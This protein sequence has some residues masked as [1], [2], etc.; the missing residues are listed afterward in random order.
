[1]QGVNFGR[2]YPA[3]RGQNCTP[4]N[5]PDISI[6]TYQADF[7]NELPTILKD[8]PAD[9]FAF[10]FVD[11][12]GWRIRLSDLA[13]MLGRRKSEVIFNFMFDFINRAASIKDPVVISGLDEL[14]PHGNWRMSLEEAERAQPSGLNSED[15]KAILVQAFAE[16]LAQLGSYAYVAETTVLRPL[17]D[18]P[19]YCLFYATR[20]PTGME[21]FRDCQ[22]KALTEQSKTR[23]ATKVK[24][25]ASSSGQG[26]F[27]QSLH[28]MGPDELTSFLEAQRGEAARTLIDL[29]PRKPD[30]IVYERLWPRVLARHVVR[31]PDVNEI[32]AHLRAQGQLEF[33]DWEKG[34]RVPQPEYKTQRS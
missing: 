23:A 34:K 21:V 12:K 20:H 33:P 19:L 9:A 4:N 16:S 3:S 2:R 22:I 10:F 11:P 1:M 7:L 25:A 26:E 30:F 6:K 18:R 13:P 32:A 29:T 31:K 15:R 8:I 5:I 24:H 14:I 17:K 27:F 28:D